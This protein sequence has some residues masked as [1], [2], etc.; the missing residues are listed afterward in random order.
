MFWVRS[1]K[2][3]VKGSEGTEFCLNLSSLDHVWNVPL[4]PSS[5]KARR[6]RGRE[7]GKGGQRHST[8]TP[9]LSGSSG[10]WGRMERR[11]WLTN[12][13]SIIACGTGIRGTE[14][15]R[16]RKGLRWL[17]EVLQLDSD[18]T[19]LLSFGPRDLIWFRVFTI[20]A[21]VVSPVTWCLIP[22][23]LHQTPF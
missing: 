21:S 4:S 14:K 16:V 7:A 5:P 6:Q 23:R 2:H 13:A 9:Q 19:D 3:E 17:L 20:W 12:K 15:T 8:S 11:I 10:L 1:Y 22:R 18:A